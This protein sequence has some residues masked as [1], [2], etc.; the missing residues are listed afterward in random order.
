MQVSHSTMINITRTARA[1]ASLRRVPTYR[2]YSTGAGEYYDL[3]GYPYAKVPRNGWSV[4]AGEL[5]TRWREKM[6]A[7]HPDRMVGRPKAEQ[8]AAESQSALVNRAYE[9]LVSPLGRA[10]YLV[11]TR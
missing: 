8:D 3:L 4:D 1:V 6:A 5:K 2:V 11:R 7:V 10:E 9:T